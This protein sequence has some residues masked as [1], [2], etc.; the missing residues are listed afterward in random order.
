MP[1]VYL[2][3][4]LCGNDDLLR[5]DLNLE[6]SQLWENSL[7]CSG[8]KTLSTLLVP[9]TDDFPYLLS[10]LGKS[11]KLSV[12]RVDG[13]FSCKKLDVENP[14]P[15]LL[16]DKNY[17]YRLTFT[18]LNQTERLKEL[19][20]RAIPPRKSNHRLGPEVKMHFAQTKVAELESKLWGNI[21]IGAL[22]L[23]KRI[24]QAYG[25]G[26]DILSPPVGSLHEPGPAAGN[27]REPAISG[28]LPG[29]PH[30]PSQFPSDVVVMTLR[31]DPFRYG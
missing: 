1:F 27:D 9:I 15:V 5:I 7:I 24:V 20:K 10:R 22:F 14:A 17:R 3:S 23:R 8:E 21:R 26:P 30:D 6:S 29:L 18:G 25:F 31:Q 28:S 12:F 13:P 4:R 2:D 11:E 19:I 16:T